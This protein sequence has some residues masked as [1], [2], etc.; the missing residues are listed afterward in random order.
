MNFEK[1]TIVIGATDESTSLI[2]TVDTIIKSCNISDIYTFMIIIPD[3]ASPECLDAIE[4]LSEKYEGRIQK[5]V[6]WYPGIGGAMR[7]SV[8]ATVSSHIM[9]LSADMPTELSCVPSMIENA[10]K[11]PDSI[12]KISRWLQKNSFR[13]YGNVKKALNFAGQ[14]FLKLLFMSSLTDFTSPVLISPVNIYKSINFS[15][16]GFPCLLEAVLIPLKAG[17]EIREIPAVCLP[18]TEGKSKNSISQYIK[19]LGTAVKIRFTPIKKLY[20]EKP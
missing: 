18:R 15:Q 11:Y 20:N 16:W 12:I 1:V 14:S 19:F 9:F 2:D 6:Q 5:V 17:K 8:E 4:F 3:N 7:S 10:K 13:E